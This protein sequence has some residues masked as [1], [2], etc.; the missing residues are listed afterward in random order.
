VRQGQTRLRALAAAC[1]LCLASSASARS[2][3]ADTPD[4]E[5][6]PGLTPRER[7]LIA[8]NEDAFDQIEEMCAAGCVPRDSLVEAAFARSPLPESGT[9]IVDIDLVENFPQLFSLH[10]RDAPGPDCVVIE[11]DPEIMAVLLE[12]FDWEGLTQEAS[13][14]QIIVARKKR[15]RT[16]RL[17]AA[18]DAFRG[19]RVVVR[20]DLRLMRSPLPRRGEDGQIRIRLNSAD[21]IVRVPVS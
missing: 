6:R 18:R 1:A 8:S 15:Y 2:A 21:D 12:R 14:D 19:R 13:E 5:P 16:P 17:M 9:F 4:P 20:G 10:S 3:Q 11:I 7:E